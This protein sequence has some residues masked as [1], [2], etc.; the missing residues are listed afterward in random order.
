[1]LDEMLIN[2]PR[3]R[4]LHQEQLLIQADQVQQ[5]DMQI[6]TPSA[7]QIRSADQVFTQ[8]HKPAD[9][10]TTVVGL[11]SAAI[12]LYDMT[13]DRFSNHEEE[14]EQPQPKVKPENQ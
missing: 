5:E 9:G 6:A 7:E 10:L 11:A 14:E 1:M 12:V 3:V 4:N 13:A 8:E 2:P